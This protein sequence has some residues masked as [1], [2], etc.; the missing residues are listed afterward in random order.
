MSTSDSK[1]QAKH[2]QDWLIDYV[3]KKVKKDP[4]IISIK[5]PLSLYG[6]DSMAQLSMIEALE[7]QLTIE[8]DPTIAYDYPTI[9]ELSKYLEEETKF[10]LI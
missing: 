10:N 2:I 7:K 1:K 3:S 8:I 4:Q 5:K 6:L 9:E